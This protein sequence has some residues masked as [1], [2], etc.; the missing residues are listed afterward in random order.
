MPRY[1][2]YL[3]AGL[4]EGGMYIAEVCKE[5]GITVPTYNRWVESYP[6][7]KEAH[8]AGE[9]DFNCFWADAFRKTATGEMPGNGPMLQLA[10][11][12]Y[13]GM[14]DKQEVHSTSDEKITTIN[15]QVLPSAQQP[16]CIDVEPV[17]HITDAS[18]E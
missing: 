12:N 10:A 9:R 15:I 8:E 7:F 3:L 14:V 13:L 4:R 17:K 6:K 1:S 11:K 18:T 2:K 5:W 16:K